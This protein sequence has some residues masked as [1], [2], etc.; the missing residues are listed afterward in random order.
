MT[1]KG[2]G[3]ALAMSCGLLATSALTASAAPAIGGTLAAGTSGLT[4][5][6]GVVEQAQYKKRNMKRFNRGYRQGYR[7]GSRHSRAPRNWRRYGSRP[8]NWNTRGCII[9]GPVWYCP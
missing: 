5:S 6:N 2:I 4:A 8:G 3:L 9:V 7:A 1:A